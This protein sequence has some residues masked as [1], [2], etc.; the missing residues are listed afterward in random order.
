M[1]RTCADCVFMK[2][3]S[4]PTA[5]TCEYLIPA[6]LRIHVSTGGFL[7]SIGYEAE[8]CATYKSRHDVMEGEKK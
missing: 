1:K 3:H 8:N 7:S 5:T 4:Q 6:W 2:S